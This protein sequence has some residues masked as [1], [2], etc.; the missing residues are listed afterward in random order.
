ME[1]LRAREKVGGISASPS[2][3]AGAQFVTPGLNT[4]D[5]RTSHAN[6]RVLQSR[7]DCIVQVLDRGPH[8]VTLIEM[9]M[10]VQA[11]PQYFTK[12]RRAGRIVVDGQ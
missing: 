4:I 1:T 12:A 7:F 9:L 2:P 3:K 8:S 6:S 11:E 10:A 5:R